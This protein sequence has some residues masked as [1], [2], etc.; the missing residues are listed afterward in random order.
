MTS[1]SEVYRAYI[2]CLNRRD[3]EHLSDYVA[4]GV[5]HNGRD[6]GLSGYRDMLVNDFEQ[7]PDLEFR[8]GLLVCE[9][10]F[11]AA[12]LDFDCSPKGAF[13][14]LAV[15]GRRISFPENVFYEFR[16][17]KIMSVWSVIDKVTVEAQLAT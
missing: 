16:N 17:E 4:E 5:Q 6:F 12:R 15:N 10:P 13:L 3:W 7:I 11:I 8:I 2:A 14:G 9:P 1:L